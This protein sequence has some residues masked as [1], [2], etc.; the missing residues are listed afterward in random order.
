MKFTSSNK[1]LTDDLYVND[2]PD[3]KCMKLLNLSYIKSPEQLSVYNYEFL[4]RQYLNAN[5]MIRTLK[6]LVML[7]SK[8][9][10]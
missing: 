2:K 4:N 7:Y 6:L 10:Y 5:L 9:L 3:A 1:S 8:I